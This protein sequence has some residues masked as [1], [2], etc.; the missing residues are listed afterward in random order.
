[1][2]NPAMNALIR[3]GSALVLAFASIS[4]EGIAVASAPA[5]EEGAEARAAATQADALVVAM[6]ASSEHVRRLLRR[7]R[8]Q[9]LTRAVGC[10]DEALSRVDVALRVAREEARGARD[11]AREGDAVLARAHLARVARLREMA[12]A[13]ASGGE[14]CAAGPELQPFEGTSV[15][16]IVDPRVA[17]LTP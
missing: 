9:K 8:T 12:R 15:R 11:A 1:M 6:D 14:M 3:G 5:P 10:L 17:P 4:T 13:G 2:R 16:V 7:A